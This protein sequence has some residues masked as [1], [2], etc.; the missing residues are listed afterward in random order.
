MDH[1]ALLQVDHFNGVVA[2]RGHEEAA[3]GRVVIEVVDPPLDSA[4]R[5]GTSEGEACRVRGGTEKKRNR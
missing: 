4:E 3:A 2:E 5:N 1:F